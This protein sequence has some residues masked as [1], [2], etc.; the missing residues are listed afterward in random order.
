MCWNAFGCMCYFLLSYIP[1]RL[2]RCVYYLLTVVDLQIGK[3]LFCLESS[4]ASRAW[5]RQV[6]KI[7][8]K[9][10]LILHRADAISPQ[11]TG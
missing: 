1:S 8:L 11:N 3:V 4:H 7:H 5:H 6:S 10:H 9:I 2:F